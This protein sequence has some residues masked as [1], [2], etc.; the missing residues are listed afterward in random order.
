MEINFNHM[1]G[2]TVILIIILFYLSLL[3]NPSPL[4]DTVDKDK[5]SFIKPENKLYYLFHNISSGKKLNLKGKCQT[6]YYTEYTLP[7]ELKV[8]LKKSITE[9]LETIHDVSNSLFSINQITNVYEQIDSNDNR[10]YILKTTITDINEYYNVSLIVDLIYYREELYIN[11]IHVDTASNSTLINYYDRMDSNIRM[12][13]LDNKDTFSDN[14]RILLD[15][16]YNSGYDLINI[17]PDKEAII[18]GALSMNSLSNYYFPSNMSNDS[19]KHYEDSGLD[20]LVKSFLPQ[21]ITSVQ[22]PSFCSK[23]DINW[24]MT[25]SNFSSEKSNSC[26]MNN[27]QTIAKYNVPWQGPGLFFDRSGVRF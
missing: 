12:G 1:L 19:I 14:I 26:I 10:R 27:N 21:N 9:I 22:A 20:G 2:I 3:T 11:Y 5:N 25:A 6:N 13:I 15:E 8:Y 7:T 18:D 17:Y 23:E 24:D 16:H 4:S